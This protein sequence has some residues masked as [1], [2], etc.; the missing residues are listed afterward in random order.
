MK[1]IHSDSSTVLF[2]KSFSGKYEECLGT[3]IYYEEVDQ[4][5]EKEMNAFKQEAPISLSYFNKSNKVL[6]L[7]PCKLPDTLHIPDSENVDLKF[8]EDYQTVMRKMKEGSL[9]IEDLIENDN[10]SKNMEVVEPVKANLP[11]VKTNL[12]KNSTSIIDISAC[13]KDAKDIHAHQSI[14]IKV[15][16]G[17]QHVKELIKTPMRSKK[18]AEETEEITNIE[19]INYSYSVLKQLY[20]QNMHYQDLPMNITDTKLHLYVDIERSIDKGVVN[21]SNFQRLTDD[22]KNKLIS[23]DNIEN[24]APP[25]QLALLINQ[26]KE[27]KKVIGSMSPEELRIVDEYGRTPKERYKILK[28]LAKDVWYH[29]FVRHKDNDFMWQK[30]N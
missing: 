25:L 19:R 4:N 8:R 11:E 26:L 20:L 5:I 16:E 9:N 22:E 2:L 21:K 30:A 13:E 18:I 1:Y 29:I 14:A 3:N 17:L 15:K 7:Q 12:S 10:E 6:K 23:L 24:L 27:E 28:Y